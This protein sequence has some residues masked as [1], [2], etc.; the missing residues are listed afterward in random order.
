MQE[1]LP[2]ETLHEFGID[3]PA[4]EEEEEVGINGTRLEFAELELPPMVASGADTLWTST[5]PLDCITP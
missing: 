3:V 1:M 4:E 5:G 2:A